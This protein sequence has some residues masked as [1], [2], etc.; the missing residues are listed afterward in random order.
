M[1]CPMLSGIMLSNLG[2]HS[3]TMSSTVAVLHQIPC[4]QRNSVM[5]GCPMPT[6]YFPGLK[7][8]NQKVTDKDL[9]DTTKK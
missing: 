5:G 8:D 3:H 2:L 6:R 4:A 7:S 9:K 1:V